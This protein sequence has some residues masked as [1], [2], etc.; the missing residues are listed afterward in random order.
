MLTETDIGKIL[1]FLMFG[2][3]NYL[4]FLFVLFMVNNDKYFILTK[5]IFYA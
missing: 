5:C 3:F 1:T 4:G 2:L